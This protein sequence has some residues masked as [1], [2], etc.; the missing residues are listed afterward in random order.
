MRFAAD[1]VAVLEAS[2]APFDRPAEP[3]R[4]ASVPLHE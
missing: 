1:V 3:K 4:V 2:G